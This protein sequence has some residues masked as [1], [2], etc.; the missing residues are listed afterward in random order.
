VLPHRAAAVLNLSLAAAGC[1]AATAAGGV[2][3]R[4][5]VV[6]AGEPAGQLLSGCCLALL[7]GY[8]GL[9]IAAWLMAA[10]DLRWMAVG[11]MDPAGRGKTRAGRLI[12]MFVVIATV[13]VGVCAFLLVLMD[14]SEFTLPGAVQPG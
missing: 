10:S 12:A 2:L 8:V 1:C 13:V 4:L 6:E 7:A 5:A 11:R 3:L 9:G 14:P